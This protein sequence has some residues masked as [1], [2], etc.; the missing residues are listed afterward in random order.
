MAHPLKRQVAGRQQRHADAL[1]RPEL[2]RPPDGFARIAPSS[3][4][5]A[6]IKVTDPETRRLIDEA[7][8]R[9]RA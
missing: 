6:S 7:V 3:P 1:D 9:A 2:R 5:S 8:A 4:H